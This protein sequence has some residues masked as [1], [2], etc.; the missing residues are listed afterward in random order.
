MPIELVIPAG[1][2]AIVVAAGAAVLRPRPGGDKVRERLEQIRRGDDGDPSASAKPSG[3]ALAAILGA[4]GGALGA[5]SKKLRMTLTRAGYNQPGA[6]EKFAGVKLFFTLV[7]L[8][9]GIFI[10]TRVQVSMTMAFVYAVGGAAL[11]SMILSFV[12]GQRVKRRTEEIRKALP[13]AIDLLEVCVSAGMGIDQAWNATG[14]EIRGASPALADEMALTSFEM[15]LGTKRPDALEAMAQRT[16]ADDLSSLSQIISQ[17]DRFGTSMAEALRL[18]AETM[19]EERSARAEEAANKMTVKM[20][21][22]MVIFIFPV[23]LIVTAGPA[24]LKVI[25]L[26]SK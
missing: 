13:N 22:P 14:D 20:L 15:L 11:G 24:A 26:F 9:V 16:G 25:E 4:L 7:G 19:R 2:F 5:P 23:V 10:V 3:D 17:A 12:L 6:A 18:F 8:G 21:L 1:I